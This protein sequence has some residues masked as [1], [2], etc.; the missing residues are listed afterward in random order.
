M[1]S[2]KLVAIAK[3]EAAYLAEWI[4]HHLSIGIQEID[5]YLN[6][7]TDNSYRLMRLISAKYAN[8]NF[9]DAD[10]IMGTSVRA[11]KSFQQIIYHFA[12]SSERRRR[13]FTH[14][15]FLDIDEYLVPSVFGQ[16]VNS[17]FKTAGEFDVLSNLWYSDLPQQ[18]EPFSRFFGESQMLQKMSIVKSIGRLRSRIGIP[19]VHNFNGLTRKDLKI[20][21]HMSN[22]KIVKYAAAKKFS[23]KRMDP[24][25]CKSLVGK[26]EP[27]FVFHRIFRSHDEYCASLMRGRRHRSNDAPIKDNRSG[28]VAMEPSKMTVGPPMKYQI[29]RYQVRKYQ[30]N[31]ERFVN[32]CNLS[33]EI[34]QG[35]NFVRQKY[36]ELE[37]LISQ[38]PELLK[39]Y[40]EVFKG[41]VFER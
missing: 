1:A 5:I 41:T 2:I 36:K 6:G 3:D 22:G 4:Y 30:R 16:N 15:A 12:W 21:A 33:D 24:N 28:F 39:Q 38:Q 23:S 14:L 37:K 9:Y 35:Q 17:M 40:S 27:W 26:Y 13:Q 11:N 8:V 29:N 18:Q 32:R 10:R 20:N 19:I 25:F 34:L 7:I 31:F